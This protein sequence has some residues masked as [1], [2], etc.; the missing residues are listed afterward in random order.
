MTLHA[1]A[2]RR[3][4][5]HVPHL[6]LHSHNTCPT[7]LGPQDQTS[8]MCSFSLREG[9]GAVRTHFSVLCLFSKS[10][11]TASV[12]F[13]PV[14]SPLTLTK[15]PWKDSSTSI[16]LIQQ[17]LLVCLSHPSGPKVHSVIC[18]ALFQMQKAHFGTSS[19]TP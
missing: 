3:R 4:R 14:T 16:S 9:R 8:N 1:A 11:W 13:A 15:Q 17:L 12:P 2:G 19:L 10:N 18:H 6:A 5:L 7:S